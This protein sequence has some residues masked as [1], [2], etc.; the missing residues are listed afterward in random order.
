MISLASLRRDAGSNP[1]KGIWKGINVE[2]N[3]SPY[4]KKKH[5]QRWKVENLLVPRWFCYAECTAH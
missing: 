3:G 2:A 4:L 1:A 5:K